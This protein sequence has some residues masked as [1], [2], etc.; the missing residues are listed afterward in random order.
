[1]AATISKD[2]RWFRTEIALYEQTIRDREAAD[3]IT[4]SDQQE[5]VSLRKGLSALRD[6]LD[7]LEVCTVEA[8]RSSADA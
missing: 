8:P 4:L 6:A 7:D 2:L 5:I 1:M 3:L